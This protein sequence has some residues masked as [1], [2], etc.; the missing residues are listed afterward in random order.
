MLL[1]EP[2]YRSRID[3]ADDLVATIALVGVGA[4][5]GV[6]SSRLV[7]L[8]ARATARR[9]EIRHLMAFA[10]TVTQSVAEEELARAACS[11]ISEVLAQQECRW[12]PGY[13]GTSADPPAR[14]QHHGTPRRLNPDRA[15]LPRHLELPAVVSAHEPGRFITHRRRQPHRLVRGASDGWHDRVTVRSDAAPHG[16][17]E[18]LFGC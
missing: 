3:D 10:R 5:L 14:W 17:S 15:K 9:G 18:Q 4:P 12:S 6:L 16:P 7:R 13:H 1:T 2:Y 11:H 8:T